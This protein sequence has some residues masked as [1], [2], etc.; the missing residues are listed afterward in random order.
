LLLFVP[1]DCLRCSC[2]C[3][4]LLLLLLVRSLPLCIFTFLL[5]PSPRQCTLHLDA[6]MQFIRFAESCRLEPLT[7]VR[8][9]ALDF[10]TAID[11]ANPAIIAIIRD[12]IMVCLCVS[13]CLCV[14][15]SVCVCVCVCVCL[16]PLCVSHFGFSCFP[17]AEGSGD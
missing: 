2:C 4:S 17:E 16:A 12:Q 11:G 10:A 6:V 1:V 3:S 13:V 9:P 7:L 5:T 15:V 8:K 14:C